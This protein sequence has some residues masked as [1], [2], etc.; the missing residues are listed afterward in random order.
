MMHIWLSGIN[1]HVSQQ[2]LIAHLKHFGCEL[3]K[4]LIV[5]VFFT[6]QFV[7][8]DKNGL[9][10]VNVGTETVAILRTLLRFI[11]GVF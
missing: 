6:G 5:F 7:I 10:S 4:I 8:V 1:I 3:F 2:E 11:L 9:E